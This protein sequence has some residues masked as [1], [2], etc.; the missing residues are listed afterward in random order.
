MMAMIRMTL[1]LLV[2]TIWMR[3]RFTICSGF[4][5]A[6][7]ATLYVESFSYDAIALCS[8]SWNWR[9]CDSGSTNVIFLRTS[10]AHTFA[11]TSPILKALLGAHLG[12]MRFLRC[13]AAR[14]AFL[15]TQFF[16]YRMLR[17]PLQEFLERQP[18]ASFRP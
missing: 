9:R 1:R 8:P 17:L 4:F 12:E 3:K 18:A 14:C 11:H 2:R 15:G 6:V 13:F 5:S 7:Y 10:F 16:G